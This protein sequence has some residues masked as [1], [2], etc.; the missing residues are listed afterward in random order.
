MFFYP[1]AVH[2][3]ELINSEDVLLAAIFAQVSEALLTSFLP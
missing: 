2:I 1:L 3:E